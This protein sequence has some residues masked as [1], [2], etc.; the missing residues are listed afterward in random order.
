MSL[1]PTPRDWRRALLD[2]RQGLA[3]WHVWSLLAITDIRQRYKRSR[4]GPFWITLSMAAFVGGIGVVYSTLF[5]QEIGTYLPYLAT[6]Y[7]IW[8]LLQGIVTDATT[9]FINSGVYLRQEAM[10]KTLFAMRLIARNMIMLAHNIIIIPV[11][12]I[13]MGFTPGW[14]TLL[15]IPGLI[16]VLLA[17]YPV[18]MLIGMVS[19]RFRDMPVIIQN[20]LQIAFFLTPVMW[21]VDQ[22]GAAAP[23]V[24]GFNPFAIFLRVVSEPLQ[25]RIPSLWTWG[26]AVLMIII[27]YAI[28]APLFAR[29]RARIVY[30]L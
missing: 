7:V 14:A 1:K 8:T 30:W 21:R 17:A 23:F 29:L 3:A 19:T 5:K 22:L 24:V 6:N 20:I 15:A 4:V 12:Y 27:L 25:G 16:L 18:V 11:V 10:S 2:A 9:V 28:T 13:L 26:V